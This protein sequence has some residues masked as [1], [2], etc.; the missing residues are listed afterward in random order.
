MDLL[1]KPFIIVLAVLTVFTLV[2]RFGWKACPSCKSRATYQFKDEPSMDTHVPIVHL[3][4]ML[5][6]L[7]CR[8]LSTAEHWTVSQEEYRRGN[9]GVVS[10]RV[11]KPDI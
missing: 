1:M 6:C 5:S 8:H 7:R 2:T 11:R 4:R 9:G 3:Y 10:H